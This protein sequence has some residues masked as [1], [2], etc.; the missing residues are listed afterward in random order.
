MASNTPNL[1]LLKKDP[2]EDGAD[3]FNIQTMLN[4]NW[5]KI[6]QAVGE[7]REELQDIDIPPASLTKPGIVQLSNST[8]G[9]REDVAATEKAVKATFDTATA[10]QTTAN[11]A[12]LAAAAAQSR[13][14]EAFTAGNERKQET[15]D[16]L[17]A[18]G[19]SASTNESW[20]S[21][22]AKMATIIKAT[23]N[24][25]AA[26]VLAGKTA[27]N[28]SG[29]FTGT[30]PNR[31][32]GGTVTP[33]TTNQTK[34]AGYYSTP[35]TVLG[36][37]NLV[38]GN[39]KK[40]I[41]IFNAT[42][43]YAGLGTVVQG[44]ALWITPNQSKAVNDLSATPIKVGAI[45]VYLSGTYYVSFIL[46]SNA[47]EVRCRIYVNGNPVSNEYYA[48]PSAT[49]NVKTVVSANAEDT[50]EIWMY[51]SGINARGYYQNF[52]VGIDPSQSIF[53]ENVVL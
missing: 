40:D 19:I 14:D 21:L 48:T 32:A 3:T 16:I 22:I 50:I 39:I 46:G 37:A 23:G 35:I 30:M 52:E 51:A 47:N 8:N 36:D 43:T 5:D 7:V 10:A 31:G 13:A 44:S 27:S 11:A 41:K 53:G 20:D 49:V 9:T 25:T 18:K 24:A 38:P 28:A 4:D 6:D 1:N 34:D 17:I 12:N 15:V 26:D 29:P 2:V 45:K 42:G 33:G